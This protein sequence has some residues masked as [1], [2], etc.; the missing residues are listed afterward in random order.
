MVPVFGYMHGTDPCAARRRHAGG[1]TWHAAVLRDG[2][3]L[4]VSLS[5]FVRTAFAKPAGSFFGI[6][7]VPLARALG[8]RSRRAPAALVLR[9]FGR[10]CLCSAQCGQNVPRERD[11]P[12]R[13]LCAFGVLC[14]LFP[15]F[16]HWQCRLC[17]VGQCKAGWFLLA[18]QFTASLIC[19][20]AAA[21]LTPAGKRISLLPPCPAGKKVS[22]LPCAAQYSPWQFYAAILFCFLFWEISLP[23]I[24]PHPEVVC[25]KPSARGD[26]GVPESQHLCTSISCAAVHGR[27]QPDGGM[28]VFASAGAYAPRYFSCSPGTFAHRTSAVEPCCAYCADAAVPRHPACRRMEE[29]VL[30]SRMPA[31]AVCA[32]FCMC[33]L[34]ICPRRSSHA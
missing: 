18:G 1:S 22:P 20:F 31:D 2:D 6:P 27:P 3:S 25:P 23:P 9:V 21:R 29:A 14:G 12:A 32:V 28:R 4:S 30:V 13:S 34:A 8:I 19:G 26:S 10:F 33:A 7:F 5:G 17:H 11:K 16:H 15:S 24:L